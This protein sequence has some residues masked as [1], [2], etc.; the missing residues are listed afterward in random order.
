M[1]LVQTLGSVASIVALAFAFYVNWLTSQVNKETR[2]T[3][4][5]TKALLE[6]T[7]TAVAAIRQ[8]INLLAKYEEKRERASLNRNTEG[9]LVGLNDKVVVGEAGNL[10]AAFEPPS[11]SATSDTIDKEKGQQ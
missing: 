3:N 8:S 9:D 2:E 6:Q 7:E 11:V 4:K 1:G 5:Q 10:G